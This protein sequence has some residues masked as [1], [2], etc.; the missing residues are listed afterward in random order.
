MTT[1]KEAIVEALRVMGG[2]RTIKEVETWVDQHYGAKWK[3]F[4]TVM[5]DMVPLE[6]GGNNTS[7]EPREFRILRRTGRGTYSL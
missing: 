1:Q 4:G 2:G 5:A 3:D 6:N 7:L